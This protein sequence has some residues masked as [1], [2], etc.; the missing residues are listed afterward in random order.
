MLSQEHILNYYAIILRFA[1]SGKVKG[2]FTKLGYQID[3]PTAELCVQ[4]TN[5]YGAEF[6]QPFGKIAAKA[7][8]SPKYQAYM[9]VLA[10]SNSTM[11]HHLSK[12]K[13]EGLT[14]EQAVQVADT[15]LNSVTA[16]ITAGKDIA[17]TVV[18]KDANAKNAEANL[19][20][21]QAAA[22]AKNADSTNKWLIPVICVVGFIV[23][24]GII[25]AAVIASKR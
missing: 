1:N 24:A 23:L 20:N 13:G 17:D 2:L 16:W 8:E 12:A 3:E 4:A 21:A 14:N 19:L 6:T 7:I 18:N 15:V 9:K 10:A 11:R 22:N 5:E 25:A